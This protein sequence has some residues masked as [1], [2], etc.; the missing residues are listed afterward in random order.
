MPLFFRSKMKF[1]IGTGVDVHGFS[2]QLDAFDLGYASAHYTEG[3]CLKLGLLE[4]P[5][6]P[7]LQ[8]HSDADVA[9]H[10]LCDALLSA[11]CLGDLGSLLG[12]DAE[13]WKDA[14]GEK[15]LRFVLKTVEQAGYTLESASLQIIAREPKIQPVRSM[16]E[17]KYREIASAKI[18][19]AATTTDGFLAELGTGQ[20]I[21]AVANALLK[22]N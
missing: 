14:T 4:F 9:T 18:A 8:G 3:N 6:L 20:A 12:V 5:G 22:S 19:V 17:N 7:R 16:M 15:V 13:K 1:S 2:Q 11:A 10:A 21:M